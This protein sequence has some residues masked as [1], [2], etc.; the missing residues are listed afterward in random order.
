MRFLTAILILLFLPLAAAAEKRT[1]TKIIFTCPLDG[2]EIT[3]TRTSSNRQFNTMLDGQPYGV[4]VAPIPVAKCPDDGFVVYDNSFSE[5]EIAV[6]KPFVLSQDYKKFKDSQ[7]DYWLIYKMK[8]KLNAPIEEQIAA[9]QMATWEA[10]NAVNWE[11]YFTYAGETIRL[12]GKIEKPSDELLFLKGELYRRT[13][14]YDNASQIFEDLQKRVRN[15][16]RMSRMIAQQITLIEE[17]I[18]STERA[19]W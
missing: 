7:T 19:A 12:I 11:Q 18:S 16:S 13:G 8:E 15:D 17:G 6:L 14:D 4:L 3:V 5:K 10:Y 1:E 2:K 9:A